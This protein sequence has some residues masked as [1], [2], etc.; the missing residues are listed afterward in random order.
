MKFQHPYILRIVLA[1]ELSEPLQKGVNVTPDLVRQHAQQC[2]R[3]G[4]S[5]F[6]H[7]RLLLS[8]GCAIGRPQQAR[9]A[10]ER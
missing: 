7:I 5:T 6:R 3:A 9:R 1:C 10:C 4:Q 2:E 8:L